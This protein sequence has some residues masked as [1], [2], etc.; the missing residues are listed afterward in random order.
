MFITKHIENT[1]LT[2]WYF[3]DQLLVLS[4]YAMG[5]PLPNNPHMRDDA[6]LTTLWRFRLSKM[7]L[8]ALHLRLGVSLTGVAMA[9]RSSPVA[10]LAILTGVGVAASGICNRRLVT[11]VLKKIIVKY[12]FYQQVYNI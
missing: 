8:G 10:N 12:E 4:W 7:L 6:L 2:T 3:T 5:F 9:T 1:M 11:G